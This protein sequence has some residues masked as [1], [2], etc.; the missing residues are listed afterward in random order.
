MDGTK[1][2]GYGKAENV[3]L[4]SDGKKVVI[5]DQTEL[6][7]RKVLLE[8]G[9][10][11]EMY[12]AIRNLKVR[13]APAIGICAACCMYCLARQIEAED[14]DTFMRELTAYG[15]YLDSSRPTAVNLSWAIRRMLKTARAHMQEGRGGVLDVLGRECRNIQEEDIAMCRAISEYGLSLIWEGDGILT[16]CNAGPLATSRYGTALGPLMLGAERGMKFKVYADET[17]PLLQGGQA[18]VL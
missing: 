13:G 8:L 9:T 2:T 4:S 18:Y 15:D 14:M 3:G 10:P 7:A 11:G 16:H 12:D 1:A 6:P 5:I 17:R